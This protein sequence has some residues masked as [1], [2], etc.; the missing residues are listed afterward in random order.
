MNQRPETPLHPSEVVERVRFSR[1]RAFAELF[2]D[3]GEAFP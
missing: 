1:E 2:S 3:R